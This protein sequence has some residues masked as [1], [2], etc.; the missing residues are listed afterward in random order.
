VNGVSHSWGLGGFTGR[1][2]GWGDVVGAQVQQDLESSF[3]GTLSTYYDAF[4]FEI[5]P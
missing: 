3:A 4:T 5:A 2:N 1:D